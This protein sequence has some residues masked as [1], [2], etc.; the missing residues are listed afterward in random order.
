MSFLGINMAAPRLQVM[1]EGEYKL[2]V[3]RVDPHTSQNSGKDSLKVQ[4]SFDGKPEA[5][6]IV[7]Y[8]ALPHPDDDEATQVKKINRLRDMIEALDVPYDDT[9]FDIEKLVGAEGWATVRQEID[10]RDGSPR[11]SVMRWQAKQ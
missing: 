7:Q 11:N 5:L 2:I 9:G 8:V 4:L 1:P 6:D 10:E 3:K